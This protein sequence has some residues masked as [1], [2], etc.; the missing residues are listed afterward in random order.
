MILSHAHI[1][2]SGRIPLLTKRGFTGRIYCTDATADLV[3]IMLKDSG[4]I[5]EKEAEWANRKAE[6]SGKPLVEPLYTF[7]DAAESAE[8]LEPVLYGQLL[9]STRTSG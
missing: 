6:R 2:H 5:H 4:Y 7:Q 8:Y 9:I 3:E 1:D